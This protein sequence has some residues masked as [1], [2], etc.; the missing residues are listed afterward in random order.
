[1]AAPTKKIAPMIPLSLALTVKAEKSNPPIA[2]GQNQQTAP[3]TTKTT[4]RALII[5]VAP[6]GPG[7]LWGQERV[8][9]NA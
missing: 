6:W 5:V 4:A 7:L 9:V 2:P 1:M 8:G 3:A